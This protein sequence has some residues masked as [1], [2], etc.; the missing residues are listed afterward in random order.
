MRLRICRGNAEDWGSWDRPLLLLVVCRKRSLEG[1][2]RSILNSYPLSSFL[3]PAV[4]FPYLVRSAHNAPYYFHLG[5]LPTLLLANYLWCYGYVGSRY[6]ECC[7]SL[8]SAGK[9]KAGRLRVSNDFVDETMEIVGEV[10][11]CRCSHELFAVSEGQV[12][13]RKWTVRQNADADGVS[14]LL[15]QNLA[16]AGTHVFALLRS[17]GTHCCC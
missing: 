2:S 6:V 12:Q 13:S 10:T 11:L 17:L 7:D 16:G 15:F 9:L 4:Q 3:L 5:W 8:C 1:L 14:L